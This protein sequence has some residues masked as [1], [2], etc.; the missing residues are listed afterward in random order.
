MPGIKCLDKHVIYIV[1]VNSV[2]SY[3]LDIYSQDWSIGYF[4][5]TSYYSITVVFSNIVQQQLYFTDL[6]NE[7]NLNFNRIP[8]FQFIDLEKHT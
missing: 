3:Y 5:Y 8:S 1:S 6:R 4:Y 7:E 2:Y